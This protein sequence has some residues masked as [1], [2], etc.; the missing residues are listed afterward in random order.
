LGGFG[1]CSINSWSIAGGLQSNAFC[2]SIAIGINNIA[3]DFGAISIGGSANCATGW[4][5]AVLGGYVNKT[6][7]FY[8]SIVGGENNITCSYASFIG[9]GSGNTVSGNYSG[10]VG[11]GILNNLACSFMSNQLRAS[12][13]S[14]STITLCVGTDGTIVRNSSDIK[15]KTSICPITYGI[16]EI[17]QL[18][19]VS[20]YWCDNEKERRGSNRQVGFIAQEVEP[21]IPEAVGQGA[22]GIYS[23]DPNKIIPALVKSIQELTKRVE[24]LEK[25]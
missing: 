17:S 4:K 18:N 24:E 10:V 8:S 25:K 15:L 2:G 7:G 21:I 6:T 11:C 5:S 23:L 20:F 19:P 12:N 13:L 1:N 3:S 14:G 9:A 16:S 22:D